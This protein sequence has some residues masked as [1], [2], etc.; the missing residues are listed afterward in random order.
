MNNANLNPCFSTPEAVKH[1]A[2][3]YCVILYLA[4]FLNIKCRQRNRRQ[5]IRVWNDTGITL[6][7][8]K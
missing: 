1:I 5:N 7:T 3:F 4:G 8:Y 6:A 2:E